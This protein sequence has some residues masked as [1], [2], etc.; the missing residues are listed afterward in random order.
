[1]RQVRFVAALGFFASAQNDTSKT[2]ANNKNKSNG[3]RNGS[4]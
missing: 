1:M 4:G 3:K 2:N